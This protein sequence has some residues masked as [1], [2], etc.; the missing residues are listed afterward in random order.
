MYKFYRFR[1]SNPGGWRDYNF[2]LYML[3]EAKSPT[4]ANRIAEE[5]GVYFDGRATGRDCS[6]CNSRWSRADDEDGVDEPTCD[7]GVTPLSKEDRVANVRAPIWVVRFDGTVERYKLSK[8]EDW[9][10]N[11]KWMGEDSA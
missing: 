3:V 6:C 8:D 7:W 2:P 11:N 10:S 5:H 4:E 1:Q 9:G